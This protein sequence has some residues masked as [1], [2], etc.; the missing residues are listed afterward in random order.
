MSA[1][2]NPRGSS[3]L[4]FASPTKKRQTLVLCRTR[5]PPRQI[6]LHAD[7][8]VFVQCEARFVFPLTFWE[9]ERL[10]QRHVEELLEYLAHVDE[11]GGADDLAVKELQ[12][13]VFYDE[14]SQLHRGAVVLV[15]PGVEDF[16]QR[17]PP[18]RAEPNRGEGGPEAANLQPCGLGA[19]QGVPQPVNR[20]LEQPVLLDVLG[21]FVECDLDG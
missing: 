14:A 17:P 12:T 11:E 8:A 18:V 9:A 15:Q 2:S 4:Y 13:G 5:R 20:S 16:G 19:N 10:P 21:E 1:C 7:A 6:R 3:F